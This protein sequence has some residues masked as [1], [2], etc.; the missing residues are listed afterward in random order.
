MSVHIYSL[1]PGPI[2]DLQTLTDCNRRIA[3]EYASED[4]LQTWKQY[5][6]IQNGNVKRRTGRRVP[7]PTAPAPALTKAKPAA[8]VKKESSV[9]E[10]T[11]TSGNAKGTS[12][13][14]TTNSATVSANSSAAPAKSEGAGKP[15][16]MKRESSNLFKSFAKAKPKA[17]KASPP[18]SAKAS[19]AAEEPIDALSDDEADGD[20]MMLDA[21]PDKEISGKSRKDREA[22]LRKMMDAEGTVH[23]ISVVLVSV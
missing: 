5:G 10:V 19:A 16:P 1:E 20:S 21:D 6:T 12:Q 17:V 23:I 3:V 15:A 2:K 18:A 9:P 7:P 22:E 4:P 11:K 14:Q 13:S 8:V